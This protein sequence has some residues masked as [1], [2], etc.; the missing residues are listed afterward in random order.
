MEFV[1]QLV[2]LV[3]ALK[4]T[5]AR[6][7][8]PLVLGHTMEDV[9]EIAPL[10]TPLLMLVLTLAHQDIPLSM[11]SVRSDQELAQLDNIGMELA[12]LAELV[13]ILAQ[14]AH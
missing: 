11:V 12:Q 6:E 3:L 1:T 14:S 4:V 13:N 8:A 10:N 7:H 2:L 5:S 9:I